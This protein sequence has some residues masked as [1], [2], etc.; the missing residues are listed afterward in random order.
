[1][2]L[3]AQPTWLP[4][5]KGSEHS[6]LDCEVL[7]L[8]WLDPQSRS[9]LWKFQGSVWFDYARLHP[10]KAFYHFCHSY[11]IAYGQYLE[12]NIDLD[13]KWSRGLKGDPLQSREVRQLISL[14]AQADAL[15]MPYGL[16]MSQRF[17][18]FASN[19]WTRPP[20][21]S[22]VLHDAESHERAETAWNHHLWNMTQ[23][24]KDPWF[25][26]DN[27]TGHQEQRR[28][29]S[30]IVGCMDMRQNKDLALSTA[31]Y[32]KRALRVE[33]AIERFGPDVV[34]KAQDWHERTMMISQS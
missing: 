2:R 17:A 13:L 9:L 21:P 7:A 33:K 29:E 10:I 30:W 1:M 12:A 16:F 18:T 25:T 11:S 27:W 31:I 8:E 15:C 3:P 5:F 22:H 23:Y 14:K 28:Y 32:D 20:R 34:S 4:A 24:A 19:G 6:F 26:V